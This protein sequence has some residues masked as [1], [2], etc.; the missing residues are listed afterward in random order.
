MQK[1]T[2][3]VIYNN[4]LFNNIIDLSIDRVYKQNTHI[5]F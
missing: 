3:Q 1:A 2:Y 5:S 4:I